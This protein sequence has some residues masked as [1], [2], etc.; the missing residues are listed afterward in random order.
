MKELE[1]LENKETRGNMIGR[2]DVLEKVKEL[3]VLKI[4][5]MLQTNRLL[6]ITRF[7]QIR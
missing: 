7:I 6:I 2:V 4:L 3:L 1:L 5:N